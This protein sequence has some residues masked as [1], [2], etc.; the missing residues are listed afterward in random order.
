M[1][2]IKIANRK[3]SLNAN[4]PA[5]IQ[6]VRMGVYTTF[7]YRAAAGF[8]LLLVLFQ[9][10]L[11]KVVW[12]AV[13]MGRGSVNGIHLS[14]L[15]AYLTLVNLQTWIVTPTITQT[16]QRRVRTGEVALDLAKPLDFL[17]QLLAR[18]IGATLGLVPFLLIAFPFSLIV[19]GMQL[20]ASIEAMMY[21][22]VSV[23]LAYLIAILIGLLMGLISFWTLETTGIQFI[24]QCINQVLGGALIP[25]WFFPS[26][27]R[28][29]TG[30]LPFQSV[31]FLPVS[32]YLGQLHGLEV[33]YAFATQVFWVITL[34]LLTRLLW[35]KAQRHMSIQGG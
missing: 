23:V 4:S 29:I 16:L 11:L 28:S 34:Y 25:L 6:I 31:A 12:T 21:Y 24:Y 33:L 3:Q 15:I 1:R 26:L 7:A 22:V 30:F 5:Y 14:T 27:L 35:Y 20:P 13:Y 32:L 18:Q 2:S 19:G 17:G 9:I 8:Q 10:Y